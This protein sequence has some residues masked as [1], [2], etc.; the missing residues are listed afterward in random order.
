M[1]NDTN[2]GVKVADFFGWIH[3]V[4][5]LLYLESVDVIST[6]MVVTK[7]QAIKDQMQAFSM[8]N[9]NMHT[10]VRTH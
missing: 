4:E 2:A 1:S 8:L 3:A 9:E 7:R 10:V 5:M 6:C